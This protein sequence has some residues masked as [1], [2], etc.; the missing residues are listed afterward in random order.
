[1]FFGSGL[2]LC[3]L[4]ADIAGNCPSREAETTKDQLHRCS[5]DR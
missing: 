5:R 4:W 1:M 3:Q 2:E